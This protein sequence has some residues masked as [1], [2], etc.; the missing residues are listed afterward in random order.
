[1]TA[2]DR[3]ASPDRGREAV[4]AAEEAAFGGTDFDVPRPYA[5]LVELA[6]GVVGGSWWRAC[7]GPSVELGMARAGAASSSARTASRRGVR[8]RLAAGQLSSAT[9]AHELAHALAGDGSGHGDRFRAAHVD[10]VALLGGR[11]LADDLRWCYGTHG[12]PPG[13]R[14]WPPPY[15]AVGSGF[16]MI[17]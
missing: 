8:L 4:Y 1:V 16:V 11:Q 15:R 3:C 6:A 10:L 12:V 9:I 5:A 7:G 2:A 17:P 13:A 14:A